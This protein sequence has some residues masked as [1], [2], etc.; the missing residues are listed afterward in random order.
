MTFRK[1]EA[2]AHATRGCVVCAS[3]QILERELVVH[4]H[5]ESGY[6]AKRFMAVATIVSLRS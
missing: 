5:E 1:G 3:T 6:E 2:H 4:T